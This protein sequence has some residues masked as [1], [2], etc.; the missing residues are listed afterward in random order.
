MARVELAAR[1]VYLS[2]NQPALEAPLQMGLAQALWVYFTAM[3]ASASCAVDV[4]TYGALLTDADARAWLAEKLR[5]VER[6]L[7]QEGQQGAV[8]LLR[9]WVA[10]IQ[11]RKE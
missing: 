6:V 5:G 1:Q 3:A 8:K 10:A 11:V 4:R 9:P 2:H 7:P